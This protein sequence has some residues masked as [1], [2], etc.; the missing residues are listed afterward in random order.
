[1]VGQEIQYAEAYKGARDI[2]TIVNYVGLEGVA[3]KWYRDLFLQAPKCAIA[4]IKFFP[5]PLPG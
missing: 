1:M 5:F 3:K 2:V 4:P